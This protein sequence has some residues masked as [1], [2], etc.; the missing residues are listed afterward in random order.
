MYKDGG[1]MG[2]AIVL[3]VIGLVLLFFGA[4]LMKLFVMLYGAVLAATMSG[5]ILD[6]VSTSTTVKA[7]IVLAAAVIGGALFFGLYKFMAR[8]VLAIM[9]G[10]FTLTVA[11]LLGAPAVLGVI[12]AVLV[13]LGL[14]IMLGK[15]DIVTKVFVVLSSIHGSTL[16]LAAIL[17]FTGAISQDHINDGTYQDLVLNTPWKVG[18]IVF[19]TFIG[20]GLQ[21]RYW[22]GDKKD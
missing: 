13:G 11:G 20:M 7:L 8:I 4:R 12:I 6:G 22:R 10:S 9:A 3:A 16:I 18:A 19:G 14:F 1:H 21:A 5:V 15:I 17:M 2:T